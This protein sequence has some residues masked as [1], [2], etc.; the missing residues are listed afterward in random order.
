MHQDL[1]RQCFVEKSHPVA[2]KESMDIRLGE[3]STLHDWDQGLKVSVS[4]EICWR[5][6]EAVTTVKIRSDSYVS[7]GSGQLTDVV[8]LI[9]SSLQRDNRLGYASH[10]SVLEHD[11][12]HGNTEDPVSFDNE[13]NLLVAELTLPIADGSS[14]LMA[15]VYA[16]SEVFCD[17][18][19]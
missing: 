15:G 16:T 17:L 12:I 5:L 18:P 6:L 10:E 11:D 7:N 2:V 1:F 3:T 8:D 14:I 19:K 9:D 4:I 13:S